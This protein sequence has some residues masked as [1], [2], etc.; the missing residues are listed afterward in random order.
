MHSLLFQKPGT[1]PRMEDM[2]EL[3]AKAELKG[4]EHTL[5]LLRECQRAQASKFIFFIFFYFGNTT[6]FTP[7]FEHTLNYF[8][9]IF[10]ILILHFRGSPYSQH[11]FAGLI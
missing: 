10:T 8:M 11:S 2:A 1:Q 5:K 3:I 7:L 6:L 9:L 4:D